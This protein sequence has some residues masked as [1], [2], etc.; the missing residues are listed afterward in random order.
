MATQAKVSKVTIGKWGRDALLGR[1]GN[2]QATFSGRQ[3]VTPHFGVRRLD[4]AFGS[5]HFSE[6]ASSRSEG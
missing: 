6:A 5:R 3:V 2:L 4:A 1:L